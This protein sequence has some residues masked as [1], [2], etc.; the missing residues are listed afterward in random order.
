M[1]SQGIPSDLIENDLLAD[2]PAASQARVLPLLKKVDLDLGQVVHEADQSIEFV[3]F[4]SDAIVSVV[5]VT[6]DGSSAEI[7]LI[8]R[9]GV[10]GVAALM[11]GFSSGSRSLVRKAGSAY[12]LAA[13][14]LRREFDGETMCRSRMLRYTQALITQ[15]AQAAVCNRHHSIQQQVC[16]CLLLTLDRSSGNQL[17]MTQQLIANTLGV[18]REGVSEAAGKL[19]RLGVIKYH[20]G[21]ITVLNR[22]L[23]EALSCECYQAVKDEAER[24]RSPEFTPSE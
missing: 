5:Y 6:L 8:G 10:V 22:P 16:R 13:A 3:Y 9:E 1:K 18:R 15:M 4:P 12:R 23:L 24:L 21:L 11:G 17:D 7:A 20:R 14:D 19:Q 2:L